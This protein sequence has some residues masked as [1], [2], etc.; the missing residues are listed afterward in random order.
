MKNFYVVFI[1][2]RYSNDML[3]CVSSHWQLNNYA[4]KQ[5]STLMAFHCI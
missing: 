1:R 4:V 2:L 3:T 5:L